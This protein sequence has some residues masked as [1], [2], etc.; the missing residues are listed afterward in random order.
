MPEYTEYVD[1]GTDL[2]LQIPECRLQGPL[3]VSVID[4]A[5]QSGVR[6]EEGVSPLRGKGSGVHIF[7]GYTSANFIIKV[8][9]R[10]QMFAKWRE[11]PWANTRVGVEPWGQ[12]RSPCS[13]TGHCATSPKYVG[14]C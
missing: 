14:T 7:G 6:L 9:S 10:Q 1:N 8:C 3:A 11:A 12:T 2:F 13:P 5:P 4:P